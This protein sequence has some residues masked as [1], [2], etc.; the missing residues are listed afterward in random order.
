MSQ[1]SHVQCTLCNT[2]LDSATVEA[3]D[4]FIL[5]TTKGQAGQQIVLA[6]RRNI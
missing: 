6:A 2:G 3:I 4:S 5:A 1:K